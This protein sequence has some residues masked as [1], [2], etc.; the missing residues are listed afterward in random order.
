M[1]KRIACLILA[2][3]ALGLAGCGMR[4]DLQRPPPMWGDPPPEDPSE[5]ES[6][7]DE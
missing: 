5:A 2:L 4:G 3:G 7:A 6:E 1:M